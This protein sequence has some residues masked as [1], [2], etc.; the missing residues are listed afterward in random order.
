MTRLVIPNW[1]VDPDLEWHDR[2]MTRYRIADL[3][4]D[5]FHT[6]VTMEVHAMPPVVGTH[7]R[8][9]LTLAADPGELDQAAELYLD[10]HQIAYRVEAVAAAFV[11][12]S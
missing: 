9:I 3:M 8:L 7:G 6:P 5:H 4:S 12:A 10:P 1:P 2:P 11:G